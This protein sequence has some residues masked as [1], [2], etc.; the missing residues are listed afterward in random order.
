MR[1]FSNL[2]HSSSRMYLLFCRPSSYRQLLELLLHFPGIPIMALSATIMPSALEQ[3]WVMLPGCTI[4][5]GSV[6]HPNVYFEA[7]PIRGFS[8][9]GKHAI[10]V[11]T[12]TVE[13]VVPGNHIHVPLYPAYV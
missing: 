10:C 4:V 11:F 9:A 1:Y 2:G 3:L 5:K 12:C 8:S 6:N 13:I 7:Y